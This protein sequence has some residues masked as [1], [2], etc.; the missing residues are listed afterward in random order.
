MTL[1]DEICDTLENADG[2]A[3]FNKEE[4]A[5]DQ[6]GLARPRVIDDGEFIERAAVQFSYS[7]GDALPLAASERNPQL[8]GTGFEAVAISMIMH[9]RNPHAPTFHAN[10]RFFLVHEDHWPFGGGFDLTPY[11]PYAA[12]VVH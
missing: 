9:P 4:I 1:Q 12:D 2:S 5:S 7:V 8:A 11:Y 10:L 3:S 6:G